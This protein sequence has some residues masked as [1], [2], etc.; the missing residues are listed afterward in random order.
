[1]DWPWFDKESFKQAASRIDLREVAQWYNG[2]EWKQISIS[3]EGEWCA[4]LT[5]VL[6][7]GAEGGTNDHGPGSAE[8]VPNT[9]PEADAGDDKPVDSGQTVQLNGSGSSDDDNDTWDY[10]WTQTDGPN[11]TL[12]D[13]TAERPTFTAP[14]GPTTLKFDLKVTDITNGLHHHNPGNGES[15]AD[16]VT[17]N[18][19][20]P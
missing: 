17:I 11:V 14:V 6:P 18:V 15:T 10:E 8:N 9:K 1:M 12:S 3:S 5:S 4:N 20:A 13:S 2:S 19:N 7:Y 16:S